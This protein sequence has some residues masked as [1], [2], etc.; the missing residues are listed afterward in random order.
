MSLPVSRNES[1][2]S[3]V[4]PIPADTMNDLQDD[5]VNLHK[6][7]GFQSESRGIAHYRE[8]WLSPFSN[9]AAGAQVETGTPWST[10]TTA[11]ASVIS[12]TSSVYPTP[13][14]LI[15]PGTLATNYAR[16]QT[17]LSWLCL[18]TTY[19]IFTLEFDFQPV[20]SVTNIT[21]DLGWSDATTYPADVTAHT[22]RVRSISGAAWNGVVGAGGAATS[23]DLGAGAPVVGTRQRFRLEY[24]GATSP[25]GVADY[26][27]VGANVAKAI[28]QLN[29]V[30][31]LVTATTMP[32]I[33]M[34]LVF[35]GYCLAGV[36]GTGRLGGLLFNAKH[37]DDGVTL[38]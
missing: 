7:F 1:Y 18:P 25:L 11:N 36:T 10:V 31:R 8:N 15:T 3:G 26:G 17:Q 34:L 23:T 28:I 32:T 37:F 16:I 22:L 20:T 33:P 12:T 5:D 4:T 9:I 35:R 6:A 13:H 2:V 38:I 19:G 21:W 30:E 27:S 24:H 14:I 29:G